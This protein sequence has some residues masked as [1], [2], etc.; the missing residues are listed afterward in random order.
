MNTGTKTR[1]FLMSA[2]PLALLL[3]TTTTARTAQRPDAV[4]DA[5]KVVPNGRS[6]AG[7]PGQKGA[8]YYALERQSS[9]VTTEFL[10]GHK[11]VAERALD[12]DIVTR[13]E[14]ASGLEVNRVRVNRKGG[15]ADRTEDAVQYA[16]PGADVMQAVLASDVEPTLDWTNR[17][18]YRFYQDNV[19]S[20]ANLRW[21]NGAI[22]RNGA[23][24]DEDDEART[25]KTIETTWANG[26]SAKTRRVHLQPGDQFDGRPVTGDALVTHVTRDGVD[27]GVANYFVTERIFAWNMPGVTEGVITKAHLTPRYGGWLFTPDMVWMNLQTLAMYE[28]KRT[29]ATPSAVTASACAARPTWVQR[30]AHL[31]SPAVYAATI[32]PAPPKNDAGCDDLHWLDGTTFRFCC[33]IHDLCYEKYGCSSSS[34]WQIW[35]SWRCDRCNGEAVWCFA[36]GGT[37]HGPYWI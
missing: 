1:Y 36:G 23:A 26:L 25:V 14:S 21:R 2:V 18:S 35:T 30:I 17:Q 16:R 8:T 37:G 6:A 22:R 4:K 34:W 33:D 15:G 9:R 5:V 28:W 19:T 10:D 12:G 29:A 20:P 31:V 11:A 27:V 13:L 24:S 32:S 3:V 7:T